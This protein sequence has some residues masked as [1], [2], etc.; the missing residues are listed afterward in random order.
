MGFHLSF[1]FSS[2][3]DLGCLIWNAPVSPSIF[4]ALCWTF[5]SSSVSL[6]CSGEPRTG[7]GA[8]GVGSHLR[9]IEEESLDGSTPP[10]A[11]QHGTGALGCKGMFLAC[12]QL[13]VQ[14]DLPSFSE[15]CLLAA[16]PQHVLTAAC[17]SVSSGAGLG[18]SP[19][20]PKVPDSPFSRSS[21]WC[22]GQFCWFS[23]CLQTCV[24]I[25]K[26]LG[27]PVLVCTE[28]DK[29]GPQFCLGPLCAKSS[30]IIMS[31]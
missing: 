9:S 30:G 21:G 26:P 3:N 8:P 27:L 23:C 18:I 1:V 31:S 15:S 16:W 17:G 13:S 5:C 7:C 2:L 11:R 12:V 25:W 10:N 14:Q 22:I 19:E 24:L 28:P 29:Q 20:L 4:R 6:S